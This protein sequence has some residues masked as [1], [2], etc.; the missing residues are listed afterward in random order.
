MHFGGGMVGNF[1]GNAVKSGVQGD[2]PNELAKAGTLQK[3]IP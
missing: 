1:D 2:S 3:L